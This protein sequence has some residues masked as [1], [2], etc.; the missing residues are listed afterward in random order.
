MRAERQEDKAVDKGW[1]AGGQGG[2]Q[3]PGGRIARQGTGVG[4]GGRRRGNPSP[5]KGMEADDKVD[6]GQGRE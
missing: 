3:G 5:M 6:S 4:Q 2:G 1:A